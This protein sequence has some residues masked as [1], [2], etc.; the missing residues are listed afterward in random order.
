MNNHSCR[1]E[2]LPEDLLYFSIKANLTD[3][4]PKYLTQK[5]KG[6]NK[7]EVKFWSS[8]EPANIVEII[9]TFQEDMIMFDYSP[10]EY[11][12]NIGINV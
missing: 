6:A 3:R 10:E 4:I 12:E 11:L 2:E 7:D 8:V 1:L 5:G 9:K